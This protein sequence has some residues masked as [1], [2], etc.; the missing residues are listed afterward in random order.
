MSIEGRQTAVGHSNL[1]MQPERWSFKP[2]ISHNHFA[3]KFSRPLSLFLV[4]T[5][6]GKECGTLLSK[7]EMKEKYGASADLQRSAQMLR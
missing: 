4:V 1:V 5:K 2:G 7:T 3:K 6:A